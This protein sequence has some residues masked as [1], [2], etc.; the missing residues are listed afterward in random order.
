MAEITE[1]FLYHARTE[2]VD[3]RVQTKIKRKTAL[4]Y[5]LGMATVRTYAEECS[6]LEKVSDCSYRIKKGFVPN[7]KVKQQVVWCKGHIYC[8]TLIFFSCLG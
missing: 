8:T 3:G 4:R 1:Q 5:V 6:Y 2:I 7:M